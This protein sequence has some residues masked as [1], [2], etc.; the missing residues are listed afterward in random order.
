MGGFG[1]LY[2]EDG[3]SRNNYFPH[4]LCHM[5]QFAK[6]FNVIEEHYVIFY[7]K[8]DIDDQVGSRIINVFQNILLINK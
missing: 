8:F 1:Y 2:G 6:Q 5:P 3:Y 4:A 7:A